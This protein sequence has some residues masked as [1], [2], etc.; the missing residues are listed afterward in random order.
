[1]SDRYKEYFRSGS[2]NKGKIYRYETHMH[3]SP[4]S[5]CACA[6]VRDSLE[7]YKALDYDGVFV[8]NHFINSKNSIYDNIEE[9]NDK[10][11]LYFSAY[12]EGLVLS[13]EIGIKVFLGVEISYKG[14]DFLIYGLDKQWYYE[15]PEIMD[16]KTT[17]MLELMKQ[18]GA[19]I[20][21]AHPFHQA[22]YINHIRLFPD[23]VHAAE[24][25]NT[26]RL[27][28]PNRMAKLYAEHYDLICFAGSD[29]HSGKKRPRDL[30]GMYCDEPAADD[31]DFINKAK[32]RKLQIFTIDI[33][34]ANQQISQKLKEKNQDEQ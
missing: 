17:D 11:D 3:T 20:I 5:A 28:P 24:V 16:M 10:L 23:S 7:F 2:E 14:T 29:N 21:Q 19:F 22:G 6:D 9:Y 4:V 1:M 18:D 30:A 8:T 32:E 31:R 15:H 33:N 34:D 25:L 26:A 13:K 27:D 12:D